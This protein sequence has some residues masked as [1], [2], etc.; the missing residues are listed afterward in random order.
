[1]KNMTDKEFIRVFQDIN[2]HLPTRGLKPNHMQLDNE[3]SPEF[4][5]LLKDKCI[6]YQLAPPFMHRRNSEE[7]DICTFNNNF[8]AGLCTTDPDFP[9][10][11]WDRLLEQAEITLNLLRPSRLKPRL[12]A[13][14]QLNGEFYFN[15]TPMAPPGTR[16]LVNDKPHNRGTWAPHEHEV[17][18]VRPAILHYRYLTSYI[19]KMDKERISDTTDFPLQH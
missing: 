11:N 7:R 1:M 16:T 4:Q 18:Y 5:V 9:M 10:Q 3:A 2:G 17:W 14:V 8:I 12:S 6:N 19:P 13:Y 15:P